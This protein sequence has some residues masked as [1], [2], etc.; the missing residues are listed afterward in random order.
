MKLLFY[1]SEDSS[2]SIRLR[3][4][5]E[6]VIRDAATLETCQ[7]IEALHEKFRDPNK[8]NFVAVFVASS[9]DELMELQRFRKHIHDLRLILILPDN[10]KDTIDLAHKLR[11]RFVVNIYSDFNVVG[12]VLK[13]MFNNGTLANST[14]EGSTML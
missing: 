3:I 9:R 4:L 8:D 11:P 14:T 7:S 13:K 6:S 12:D 1:T 10:D 2:N 5:V